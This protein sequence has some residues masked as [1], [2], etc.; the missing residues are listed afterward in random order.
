M[1]VD[2]SAFLGIGRR[3]GSRYQVEEFLRTQQ[4][5]TDKQVEELLVTDWCEY[6]GCEIKCLDLYNG[7]DW[8]VGFSVRDDS[9]STLE[10]SVRNAVM[11]WEQTFPYNPARVVW[12]VIYS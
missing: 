9:P 8:F 6:T 5:F 1:S 4:N 3:F 10:N 12:A 7:N 11:G 2:H